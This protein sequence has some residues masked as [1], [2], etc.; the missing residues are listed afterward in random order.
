MSP[1]GSNL[2]ICLTRHNRETLSK[3]EQDFFVR[4]VPL[5]RC[6]Q[7]WTMMKAHFLG[8]PCPRGVLPSL[9]LADIIRSSQWGAHP[10]SK[11]EHNNRYCNNLSLLETGQYWKGKVQEFEGKKYRAYKDWR[12]CGID[13]SDYYTFTRSFDLVLASSKEEDQI[14]AMSVTRPDY[15]KYAREISKLIETYYL[16]EF[17]Y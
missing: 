8:T 6:V 5:A 9:T 14:K 4:L 15:K 17:N 10:L 7:R 1:R 12:E 3:Q 16:S 13:I 11:P 2:I